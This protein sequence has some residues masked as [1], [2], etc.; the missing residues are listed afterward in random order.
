M[1]TE[2]KSPFETPFAWIGGE[3]AVRALSERFYDLMDMEPGYQALRA[4]HGSTLQDARDKLFW[5]L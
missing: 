4:A 3:E 1:N 2:A 5:F